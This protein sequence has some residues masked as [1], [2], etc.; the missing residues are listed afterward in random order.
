MA[1]SSRGQGPQ[2]PVKGFRP[3]KEPPH[4][5]KQQAMRQYG[6]VDARQEQLLEMF[7]GR[8]PAESRRLLRRWRF[9][10]LAGAILLAV[11]GA[12]L[13]TWSLIAGGITHVLAGVV[14]YLWWRLQRQRD[15]LEAMADAV[16]SPPGKGRRKPR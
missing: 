15:A 6:Q 11:L 13:Y 8:S 1:R 10:L 2:R 12:A 9:G 7:A 3:G 4:I 5:R 16:G 14:L